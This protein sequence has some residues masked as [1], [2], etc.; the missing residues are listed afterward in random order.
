M[1]GA[2]SGL[3]KVAALHFANQ[4]AL[5]IVFARNEQKYKALVEEYHTK[6]PN[7]IGK[8]ELVEGNLN[9]LDSV[10]A[11]CLEVKEK[12]PK[13]DYIINNAGIM[14][15]KFTESKDG[16]EETLQVNLLSP[17]LICHILGDCLKGSND[18]KIIFT[19]SGLHQG[20]I[21][22]DNMEFRNNFSSFKSYRHSKLGVI[23]MCRLLAKKLAKENIGIYSQHPGMV[24]T[25]LGR[26]AGWFS[27]LIFW[28]MGSSPKK[29]AQNLIYLSECKNETLVS[30]EYYASKQ[31]A[32]TTNESYDMKV[33]EQLLHAT[34]KYLN[35]YIVESSL[36]TFKK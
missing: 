19:A 10:N 35:D 11:A 25:K 9:S 12:H 17:M 29:G 4:G 14:N 8:I 30:G 5:L 18:A 6:F 20:E 2:T 16:I 28:L 15:F 21:Y 24:R 13:L 1:T 7:G 32:K 26:S 27:R 23:L 31:I 22:F 34:Q 36:V 3:G 33:A